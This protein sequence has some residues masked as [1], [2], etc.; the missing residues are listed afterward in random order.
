MTDGGA[1][2]TQNAL[3][4][5]L[6]LL[7][8]GGK[9]WRAAYAQYRKTAH[10]KAKN[11]AQLQA[12]PFCQMELLMTKNTIP[13]HESHHLAT[14][15]WFCERIGVDLGSVSKANHLMWEMRRLRR[16]RR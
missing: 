8:R 14:D 3:R 2:T 15:R 10:W 13:A 4:R 11:K 9:K 5:D 16:N 7:P 12:Y 1:F 6:M